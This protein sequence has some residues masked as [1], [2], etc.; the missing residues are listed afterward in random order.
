[1]SGD[2]SPD[3]FGKSAFLADMHAVVPAAEVAPLVSQMLSVLN[4]NDVAIARELALLP[5]T[6][7]TFAKMQCWQSNFAPNAHSDRLG[8]AAAK[9]WAAQALVTTVLRPTVFDTEFVYPLGVGRALQRAAVGLF[10]VGQLQFDAL[11]RLANEIIDR[12]LARQVK[13]IAFIESPF[14]NTVP[15]QLLKVL[16]DDAGLSAQIVQWNAPRNDRP[17][18]GRTVDD[19]AADCAESTARFDLVILLDESLTGT[20]FI[21]LYDVLIERIGPLR[22]LP[23]AMLFGDVTRPELKANEN[24]KRLI[25]RVQ[26]QAERVGFPRGYVAFPRQRPFKKDQENHVFWQAPVIWNDSDLIAGKRKINFIFMLLDHYFKMIESMAEAESD[27]R[28]FLEVAWSQN[29]RGQQFAF[30]PDLLRG[31]FQRVIRDLPLAPFKQRLRELA[32]A[33]FPQ[34]YS[35]KLRHLDWKGALERYEWLRNTLLLEATNVIGEG[36]AGCLNNAVDTVFSAS[37]FEHAPKASRDLDAT[38]YTLPFNDTIRS[39]NQ[40]LLEKLKVRAKLLAGG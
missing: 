9:F 2:N 29:E 8:L 18:E 13:N 25:D 30:K 4:E 34:D 26:P 3:P 40:A 19:A 28:R 23:I 24:R 36:R 1:M 32:K 39:F 17:N 38:L 31:F 22:F 7:A 27:F 16:A 10:D 37:F 20:R 12:L 6:R 14:G 21:K 33:R 11:A 5:V 15:T 35:G